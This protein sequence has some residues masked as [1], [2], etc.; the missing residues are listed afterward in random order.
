M[1]QGMPVRLQC[2]RAPAGD[3]RAPAGS[4]W[5]APGSDDGGPQQAADRDPP[6]RLCRRGCAALAV[7][8]RHC[9]AHPAGSSTAVP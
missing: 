3:V 8:Q 9:G 5:A 4:P 2:C 7:R 1:R 6:L